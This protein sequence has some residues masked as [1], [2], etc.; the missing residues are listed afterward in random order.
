MGYK[1]L[2]KSGL[3]VSELALGT[4]T[5]SEDWGWG[6]AAG[7][8]D[9]L[10]NNAGVGSFGLNECLSVE[11]LQTQTFETLG[12]DALPKVASPAT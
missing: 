8:I 5:F 10:I 1:I 11:Q 9:V 2:G 12:L 4:M 6:A 3:R 7:R